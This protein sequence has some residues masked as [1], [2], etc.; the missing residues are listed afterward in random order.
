MTSGPKPKSSRVKV[1]DHRRR[2]RAARFASDPDL[3][4]RCSIAGVPGRSAPAIACCRRQPA[5]SRGSGL[6]RFDFRLASGILA[7]R[8]RRGEV[9]TVAGAGDYAGKSRPVVIVQDD[10]FE[11]V[12]SLVVCPFTS[13]T[14]EA[15]LFRLPG[16]AKSWQRASRRV[17]L[18]GGQGHGRPQVENGSQDRVAGRRGHYSAQPIDTRLPMDWRPL[19][20][21]GERPGRAS[22]KALQSRRRRLN[23]KL[24]GLDAPSRTTAISCYAKAASMGTPYAGSPRAL[25]QPQWRHLVPWPGACERPRVHRSSTQR[26][27]RRALVTHRSRRLPERRGRALSSKLCCG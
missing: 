26:A 3:G 11:G 12:D 23:A 7:L 20:E 13:D 4:P 8:M 22:T 10:S 16:R 27:L 24:V 21:R 25:P 17:S 14:T 6:R 2:L 5:C 19:R 18:D 9:W 1:R 15:P